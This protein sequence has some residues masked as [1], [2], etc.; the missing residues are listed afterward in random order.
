MLTEHSECELNPVPESPV[1][2]D[3]PRGP[4]RGHKILESGAGQPQDMG[5]SL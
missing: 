4:V 2:Q 3:R 1:P 5:T